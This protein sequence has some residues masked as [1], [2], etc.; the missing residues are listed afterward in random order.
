MKSSDQ[1][2]WSRT[3]VMSGFQR[4]GLATIS[5]GV[6]LAVAWLINAPSSCFFL[7]VMVSG[8]YG[9][10]GPGLLSVGLSA[11][12]FDYFFLP[13]RFH[14]SLEPFSD[15]QFAAFLAATLLMTGLIEA[16]R[17]VELAR[18]E[19]SLRAQTSE[20]YLAE[21]QR[22]SQTGSFGWNAS[23]GKLFWSEETFRITGYDPSAP[24]TFELL[25]E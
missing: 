2:N 19:V 12:A 3:G 6:A 5:C 20:S 1:G 11:L 10:K 25:F 14:L 24:L 9:G 18:L 13:P 8:L 22:L 21:A 17:R 7:A 23:T 4:Y 16:K 15:L